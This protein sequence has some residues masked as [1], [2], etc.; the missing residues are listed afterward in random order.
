V[1]AFDG[2]NPVTGAFIPKNARDP[3]ETRAYDLAQVAQM[4]EVLPL[5]AHIERLIESLLPV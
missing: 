4:L 2:A 3:K 5:L 1:G